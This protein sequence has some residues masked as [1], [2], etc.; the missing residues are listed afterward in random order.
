MEIVA[1]FRANRAESAPSDFVS[2]SRDAVSLASQNGAS[3]DKF[4]MTVRN[5]VQALTPDQ[6]QRLLGIVHDKETD[7]VFTHLDPSL[8]ANGNV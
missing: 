6:F 7:A 2:A 5:R 3:L 1:G 8:E 4:F